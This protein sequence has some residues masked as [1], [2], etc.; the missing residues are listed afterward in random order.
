MLVPVV[1]PKYKQ[2]VLSPTKVG[3]IYYSSAELYVKSLFEFIRVKRGLLPFGSETFVIPP[4]VQ[5]CKG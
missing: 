1:A 2:H 3:K 5:E 4:A